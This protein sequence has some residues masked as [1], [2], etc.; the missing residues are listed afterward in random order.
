MLEQQ[1]FFLWSL[2]C[3]EYPFHFEFASLMV[4]Y[5]S[6]SYQVG[7]FFISICIFI[8]RFRLFL[9]SYYWKICIDSCHLIGFIVFSV[10]WFLLC[11]ATF[12]VWVIFFL[13]LLGWVCL[14][15]QSKDSF[16]VS[17]QLAQCHESFYSLFVVE[18]VSSSSIMAD[19]FTT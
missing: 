7:L 6:L 2:I 10:F 3:S 9:F 1:Y 15:L 11:L 14:S 19:V 13:Y 8:D 5:P 4:K 12:L 17:V 16:S 18:R